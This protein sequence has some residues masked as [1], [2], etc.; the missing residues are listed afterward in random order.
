MRSTWPR[1]AAI[2]L[3]AAV[4]LLVRSPCCGVAQGISAGPCS[5]AP[6]D[7]CC[8]AKMRA[9][10][11]NVL[12]ILAADALE[13]VSGSD[14]ALSQGRA[15]AQSAIEQLGREDAEARTATLVRVR[16]SPNPT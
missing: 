11:P 5:S 3:A 14:A 15:L 9:Q 6:P 4:A 8:E 16:V 2:A 1:L 12:S 7:R 13:R 10:S